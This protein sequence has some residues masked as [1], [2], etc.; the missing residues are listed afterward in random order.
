MRTYLH[1]N[2]LTRTLLHTGYVIV[3]MILL[4]RAQIAFSATVDQS[5][6]DCLFNS[7]QTQYSELFSP[8]TQT[9][10]LEL[11]PSK[12]AFVRVYNNSYESG[13]AVY[14]GLVFY[15]LY[16]EWEVF[17]EFEYANTI[18]NTGCVMTTLPVATCSYSIS[19]SSTSFSASEGIG[20]VTISTQ[21]ECEWQVSSQDKWI[22]LG[23]D[24]QN[25]R[26]SNYLNSLVGNTTIT[27]MT[28]KGNG[29][30]FYSVPINTSATPRNAVISAAGKTFT[31]TQAGTSTSPKAASGIYS[32]NVSD[33]GVTLYWTDN[34]SNEDGFYIFRFENGDWRHLTTVSAN[35][36]SYTDANVDP[37]AASSSSSVST[38]RGIAFVRGRTYTYNIVA[39]NNTGESQ[40]QNYEVTIPR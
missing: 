9:V 34:S 5:M 25:A 7:V 23:I 18:F 13:L 32:T 31:I 3:F 2:S 20:T 11:E 19:P 37:A 36:T 8:A 28:G 33:K 6:A 27:P 24:E 22:G 16:G 39:Y 40:S 14:E 38:T 26:Y 35:T 4:F 17:S 10:R 29:K 21:S 15:A 12:F 30:V 1:S